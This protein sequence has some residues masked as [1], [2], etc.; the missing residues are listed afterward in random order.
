M[1]FALPIF[2]LPQLC[3]L[4]KSGDQSLLPALERAWECMVMRRMYITGGI[5]SLPGLEGF[6]KDYELDR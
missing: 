6:G 5:G 2:K 1:Q 3:W 4:A